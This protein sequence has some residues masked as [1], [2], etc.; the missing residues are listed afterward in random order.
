MDTNLSA[1]TRSRFSSMVDRVGGPGAAAWEIHYAAAQAR[2]RGEDVILL[3]VGDPDFATPPTIVEAAID[4]L[5]SGD[6]HYADVQGRPGLRQAVADQHQRETGRDCSAE[7]VVILAGAQNALFVTA[8]CLC[9]AGDEVLV[10]Q[11]MYV[12]YEAVIRA[13]GA[14]PIAV[15]AAAGG[16]RLD[17]A[18]LAARVTPRSRAILFANPSNPTGTVM[19]AEELEALAT[20][21]RM[22]DLWVIADE[23]YGTLTFD[24]PHLPIAALPEM[25]ERTVTITS[26]SKSHA[27]TGWRIGW[28]VGPRE[29]VAHA[30][31]LSL[32]TLYGLPGFVQAAAEHAL[33]LG[34]APIAEMREIY[35]ARRDFIARR[36]AHY[37]ELRCTVPEAGMF[38]M[39]DVS[40]T[41]L[42]ANE[43][44]W[45]LFRAT[46]VSVLDGAAFGTETAK[47]LRLSFTVCEEI[48]DEAC[49][50]IGGFL[51]TLTPAIAGAA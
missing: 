25:A 21:A 1:A 2:R 44:A 42:S 28:A 5:R 6:T 40:A 3:S 22:H 36:L 48:L 16:F 35:R 23:V 19:T 7:N 30:T 4:A 38:M 26:L 20:V 15:P 8:L 46:G 51:A 39:V 12:T 11:P 24:R 13:S 17:A 31:N 9:D 41:G 34:D 37:P 49:R 18:A 10:P 32:C 29:F 14:V 45:A 43:F 27:M 50:R 33:S 47:Y